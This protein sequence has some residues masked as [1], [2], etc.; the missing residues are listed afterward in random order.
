MQRLLVSWLQIGRA[1]LSGPYQSRAKTAIETRTT[2]TTPVSSLLTTYAN[3]PL[4]SRG[5]LPTWGGVR[6]SGPHHLAARHYFTNRS[7]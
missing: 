2:T 4:P 3:M 7:L 1:G 5:V 6:G